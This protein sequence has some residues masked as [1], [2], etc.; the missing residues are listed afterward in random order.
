MSEWHL[1]RGYR[2]A[3]IVSGLR[4]EPNR[5]DVAVVISDRPATAAGV[6]TQNRVCAAPVQVSRSRLPRADARAIVCCSGNANA[7]TGER[8]LADARR[9]AALVA[10]ELGCGPEQVL[11]ASTGVIGR[12]LPMPILEA[13]IPKAVRE[14]AAGRSPDLRNRQLRPCTIWPSSRFCQRSC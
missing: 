1:A 2:Y 8:G 13:G 4:S 6:F 3:G 5:R 11:V 12:P 9:M 7:C 14:A 10:V